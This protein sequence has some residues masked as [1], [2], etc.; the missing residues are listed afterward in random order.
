[1]IHDIK[2][3]CGRGFVEIKLEITF[4][5]TLVAVKDCLYLQHLCKYWTDRYTVC[6]LKLRDA[7]FKT[8]LQI[9]VN[10]CN[11]D[12]KTMYRTEF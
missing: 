3:W 1:M 12:V 9:M 6:L 11:S 2:W 8:I 7:R 5:A 10:K 4:G